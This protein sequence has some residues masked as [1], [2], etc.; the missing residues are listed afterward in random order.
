[1]SEKRTPLRVLNTAF[2]ILFAVAV[3]GFFGIFYQYH[4]LYT[5]GMQLF[6]FTRG[7]FWDTVLTPG[8]AADYMSRFLIQFYRA[9]LLGGAIIALLLSGLGQ[10][11]IALTKTLAERPRIR[12]PCLCPAGH[13]LDIV[14][15]PQFYTG[16]SGGTDCCR[17]DSVPFFCHRKRS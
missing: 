14:M 11:I 15:Q 2:I 10:G 17:M 16:R 13:I 1:M 9:P 5:E 12:P 8:G 7:Y 6:L 3:T 4:L